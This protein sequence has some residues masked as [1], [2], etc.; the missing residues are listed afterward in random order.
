MSN[1]QISKDNREYWS[2]KLSR[3]FREKKE[4]I[5]SLHQNEINDQSQKNYPIFK[6]RLNYQKNLMKRKVSFNLYIKQK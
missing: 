4:V 5:E 6:K 3:K 2:N 1:K